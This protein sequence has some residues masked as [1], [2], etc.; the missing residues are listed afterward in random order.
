[1]NTVQ[2]NFDII[3]NCEERF[4]NWLVFKLSCQGILPGDQTD[5]SD[6]L[7]HYEE[8]LI[9]YRQHIKPLVRW[10]KVKDACYDFNASLNGYAENDEDLIDLLEKTAFEGQVL[11]LTFQE[12]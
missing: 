3:H 12:E 4:F 10:N 8:D 11:W 1:M 5:L 2:K 6:L 7:E 9:S